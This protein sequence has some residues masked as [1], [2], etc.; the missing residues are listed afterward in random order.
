M[1]TEIRLLTANNA[2]VIADWCGGRTAIQHSV[3]DDGAT[4]IIGVNVPTANGVER[5]QPG[6]YIA[7]SHSGIFYVRKIYRQER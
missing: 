2:D 1:S 3:E 5:A 7:R 4:P 6:D